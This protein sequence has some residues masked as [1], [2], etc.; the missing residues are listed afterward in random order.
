[1][2]EIDSDPISHPI[3]RTMANFG[4]HRGSSF[5]RFLK[6]QGMYEEVRAAAIK[7]T[8]A[9]AIEDQKLRSALPM[10]KQETANGK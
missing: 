5:D 6:A 8:V 4:K 10:P 1:M 7:R 9:E 3:S 2:P